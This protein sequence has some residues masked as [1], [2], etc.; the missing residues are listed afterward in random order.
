[1]I[2]AGTGHR[3]DRLGDE[4]DHGGPISM[5]IYKSVVDQLAVLKPELVISGFAAGFDLLLAQ[6]AVD[7][8]LNIIA[9]LPCNDQSKKWSADSKHLYFDLLSDPQVT[10]V[11]VNP[12]PYASWKFLERDRWMVAQ[13][14]NAE[15]LLL[16]C[17]NGAPKTG[18]G[19]TVRMAEQ[20]GKKIIN[21]WND[22]WFK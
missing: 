8:G 7:C 3:P 18:T 10:V 13:L 11:E 14:K 17:W 4:W 5:A 22:S 6:A 1:M 12:G 15:D 2:I 16:A 21:I 19:A 9:A 20:A